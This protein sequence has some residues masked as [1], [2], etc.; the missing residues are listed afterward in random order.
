MVV[1]HAR[2]IKGQTDGYRLFL[3][4][5][6]CSGLD[7]SRKDLSWS[8]MVGSRLTDCDFAYASLEGANLFGSNLTNSV[9]R[10]VN[11]TKADLRGAI[12]RGTNLEYANLQ[13]TNMGKGEVFTVDGGGDFKRVGNGETTIEEANLSGANLTN[14][15]VYRVFGAGTDLSNANFSHA[16][17]NEA[18]F[19][20][21]NMTRH[22]LFYL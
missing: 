15:K 16:M 20:N 3:N 1:D 17:L 10:R 21:S 18:D 12:L 14:A 4:F 22:H 5:K 2:H 13:E 19:S 9:M 7:F 8:E 6:N 11:F